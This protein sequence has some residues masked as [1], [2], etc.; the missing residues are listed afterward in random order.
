MIAHEEIKKDTTGN[1]SI[2]IP[3]GYRDILKVPKYCQVQ[4]ALGCMSDA[5]S[6]SIYQI[7]PKG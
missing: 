5:Q 1:K 7:F 3:S 2:H 6:K 4:T